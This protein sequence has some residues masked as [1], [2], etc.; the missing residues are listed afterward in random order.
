MTAIHL[1][2]IIPAVLLFGA[3]AG[4]VLASISAG[5]AMWR[6]MREDDEHEWR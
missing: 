6:E 1:F 3:V 5:E 4:Y 2:W